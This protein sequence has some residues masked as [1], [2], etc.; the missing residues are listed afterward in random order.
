MEEW[1][2]NPSCLSH[3]K[4]TKKSFWGVPGIN[5]NIGGCLP[6]E[7]RAST[8]F[9]FV[10]TELWLHLLAQE[11]KYVASITV[12]NGSGSLNSDMKSKWLDTMVDELMACISLCI[13]QSCVKEDTL[14][15]YWSSQ[16][17]TGTP[18]FASL[19]SSKRYEIAV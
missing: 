10:E 3:D 14:Q 16:K 11:N 6:E 1:K 5:G 15:A 18:F 17:S 9:Q 4:P 19:M 7:V 2:W 8:C 13:I 12:Q